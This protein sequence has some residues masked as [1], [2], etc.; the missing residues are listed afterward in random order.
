MITSADLCEPPSGRGSFCLRE[1]PVL[2]K[3]KS[4]SESQSDP[5]AA[6]GLALL[7]S[8]V[9]PKRAPKCWFLFENPLIQALDRL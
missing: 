2:A 1:S 3:T 6:L 4:S 7:L 8:R 9:V 5:S